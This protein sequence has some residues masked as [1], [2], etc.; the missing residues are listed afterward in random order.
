[1]TLIWVSNVLLAIVMAIGFAAVVINIRRLEGR[2]KTWVQRLSALFAT[3]AADSSVRSLLSSPRYADP[4]CLTRHGAKVYSQGDEDGIL[5]EIFRR[6]GTSSRRFLE[7]GVGDGL[8][9]N[10][11]ALLL[12]GWTG[13]WIDGSPQNAAKIR[14][15][16]GRMLKDGRLEFLERRVTLSTL[17]EILSA[18]KATDALD[19]LGLDIDGNDYHILAQMP[20]TARVVVLEY[21][22]RFPPPI[23]WVMPYDE[24]H[25]WSG[26]DRFGASLEA[27]TALLTDRGYS[28]VG[29]N[30]TG[31]NAFY[32]RNDLLDQD[33]F[34]SPFTAE[35]HYEPARYWLIAGWPSGHSADF[36]PR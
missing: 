4:R 14:A 25:V 18:A 9:N 26:S 15:R 2:Q 34:L 19:L 22:A 29:C 27:Y 30:L 7:I 28:L 5:A 12:K 6:I 24:S 3:A 8:E 1:M 17:P 16:F 20:L 33:L 13:V 32:V 21:N 11:L 10:T 31:A 35:L 23:D 36:M